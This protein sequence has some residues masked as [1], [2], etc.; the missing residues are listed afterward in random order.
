MIPLLS[1]SS[2]YIYDNLID[3]VYY[4]DIVITR[5]PLKFI[6][7]SRSFLPPPLFSPLSFLSLHLSTPLSSPLSLSVSPLSTYLSLFFSLSHPSL[8]LS[9]SPLKASSQYAAQLRDAAT[10]HT[11]RHAALHDVARYVTASAQCSQIAAVCRVAASRS[12]AAY[13]ELAFILSFPFFSL[14]L[15]PLFLPTLYL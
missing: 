3:S 8:M 7:L 13:C 4:S 5:A 9:L 11:V 1:T 14:P 2:M 12:C 10:R 6:S 15:S